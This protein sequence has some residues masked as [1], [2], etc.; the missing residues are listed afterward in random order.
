LVKIFHNITVYNILL[1]NCKAALKQSTV[2][3]TL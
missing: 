1:Y 3:S 2:K